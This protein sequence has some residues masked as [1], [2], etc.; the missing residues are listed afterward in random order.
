MH[1][2]KSILCMII[3]IY[4]YT[5]THTYIFYVCTHGIWK[6]PGYGLNLSYS[7]SNTGSFNPL[8]QPEIKPM[9]LQQSDSVRFLAH[10]ATAGTLMYDHLKS[11]KEKIV[12]CYILLLNISLLENLGICFVQGCN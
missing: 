9:P 8:H 6:F 7:C 12:E 11:K 1:F 10:C 3:Y 5:Y 4:I 2:P